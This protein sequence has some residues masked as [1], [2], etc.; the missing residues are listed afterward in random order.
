MGAN[1]VPAIFRASPRDSPQAA[2]QIVA[3]RCSGLRSIIHPRR[4]GHTNCVVPP[5]EVPSMSPRNWFRLFKQAGVAWSDDNAPT[6]GAALAYYTAFSLAPLLLIAISM[7]SLLLGEGAARGGI[8]EE[9]R[10]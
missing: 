4:R 6:L 1:G 8:V 5:K 9:I 2:A 10:K 7:A 3:Q